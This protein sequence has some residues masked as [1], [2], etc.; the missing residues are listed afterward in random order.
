MVFSVMLVC[1]GVCVCHVAM[2]QP[3]C[4]MCLLSPPGVTSCGL[5]WSSVVEVPCKTSIMVLGLV[6]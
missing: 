5:L 1:M 4:F 3:V 2:Q 6:G